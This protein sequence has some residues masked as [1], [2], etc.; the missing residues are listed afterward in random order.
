MNEKPT[1]ALFYL[2][3]TPEV[4]MTWIGGPLKPADNGHVW[5]TATDGKA[6][7]KVQ[8][9]YVHPTTKDQTAQRI[10]RDKQAAKAKYN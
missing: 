10:T 2:V 5:L 3:Q 6:V 7:L 1:T 9:S 4:S 8:S